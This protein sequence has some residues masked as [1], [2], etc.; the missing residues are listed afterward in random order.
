[1]VELALTYHEENGVLIPDIEQE[2]EDFSSLTKYGLMAM[3]YLKEAHPQR[4]RSLRRFGRL[5]EVLLP[6]QEE[7][8]NLKEK[9]M[10]KYLAKHKPSNPTSFTE[11]YQ[12]MMQGEMQTEEIVLHQIVNQYH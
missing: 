5:T 1:M 9:L 3:D 2:Q 7:A 12:I 11:K 4:Y 8:N 6:V 10:K